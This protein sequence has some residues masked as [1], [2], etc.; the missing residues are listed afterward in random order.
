MKKFTKNSAVTQQLNRAKIEITLFKVLFALF[1]FCYVPS[2]FSQKI[3]AGWS[4]SLYLCNNG[5]KENTY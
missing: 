5:N 1:F 3:A 2:S 4:H